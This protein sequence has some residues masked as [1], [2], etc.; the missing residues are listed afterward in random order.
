[1]IFV[2][3]DFKALTIFINKLNDEI[4]YFIDWGDNTSTDWIGPYDSGRNISLNHSWSEEGKYFIKAKSRDEFGV[5]SDWATLE[6]N[7]PNQ[8]TFNQISKIILWLLDQFPFLQPYF[9]QF[10]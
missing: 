6:I 5:E 9:S 10:H 4:Y 1:M 8:K 7:M 3:N 2:L